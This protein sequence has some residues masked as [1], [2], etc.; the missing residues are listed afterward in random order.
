MGFE[1]AMPGSMLAHV[2]SL[3]KVDIILTR[4]GNKDID[5]A[6]FLNNLLNRLGNLSSFGNCRSRMSFSPLVS[7]NPVHVPST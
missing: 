2:H 4:I 6:K 5:L 1:I 3:E 7:N